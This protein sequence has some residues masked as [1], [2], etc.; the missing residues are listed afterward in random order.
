[1]YYYILIFNTNNINIED[2][3]FR[4]CIQFRSNFFPHYSRFESN[5][6]YRSNVSVSRHRDYLSSPL[7][8]SLRI[9]VERFR[10]A[11]HVA[12]T[13]I[14]SR[15]IMRKCIEHQME[16]GGTMINRIIPVPPCICHPL[17]DSSSLT[18]QTR[19]DT[20]HRTRYPCVSKALPVDYASI[21]RTAGS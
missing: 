11:K 18:V 14:R 15:I 19:A 7:E 12:R 20:S 1:M 13:L 16:N 21:Y 4:V 9:V 10:E 2:S 8:F 6:S 3:K 17:C 5:T